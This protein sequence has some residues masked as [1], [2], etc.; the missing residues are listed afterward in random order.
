MVITMINIMMINYHSVY[1]H[2]T[3]TGAKMALVKYFWV[4]IGIFDSASSKFAVH[5]WYW[6]VIGIRKTE[7][8]KLS[9]FSVQSL[10]FVWL[11]SN[12][13]QLN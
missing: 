8:T 12:S 3:V 13:H 5:T 6:L 11:I 9:S 2:F 10:T 1:L 7:M 4:V